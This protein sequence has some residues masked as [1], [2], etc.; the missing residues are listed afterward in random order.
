MRKPKA[1]MCVSPK[2]VLVH[3]SVYS[4]LF[5]LGSHKVASIGHKEVQRRGRKE[6][7]VR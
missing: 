6:L 5:L 4:R 3:K 1:C 2:T 7:G